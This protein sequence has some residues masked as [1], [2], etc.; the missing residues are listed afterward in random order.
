M[1]I[2]AFLVRHPELDESDFRAIQ[3]T[4]STWF[5]NRYDTEAEFVPLEDYFE[6]KENFELSEKQ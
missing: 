4:I 6:P 3:A 5:K 1:P 2:A